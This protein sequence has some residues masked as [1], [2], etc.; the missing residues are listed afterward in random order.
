LPDVKYFSLSTLTDPLNSHLPRARCARVIARPRRSSAPG[1]PADLVSNGLLEQNSPMDKKPK[2]ISLPQSIDFIAEIVGNDLHAKRILSLAGAAVS[3][4]HAGSLGAH[5]I[6]RGLAAVEGKTDKHTIKQVDRLLSN[7]GLD[8]RAV[9]RH[10][11][12][13]VVGA[14]KTLIVN[15]DWPDFD[16]DGQEMIVLSLQ[17]DHGRATPLVWLC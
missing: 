5:A 16:A 12:R 4:I 17:T 1:P 8:F 11:V 2:I 7:K 15:M 14:R 3:V 10:W 13:W 6:G 9:E